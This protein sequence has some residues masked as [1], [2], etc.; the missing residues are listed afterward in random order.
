[1][2]ASSFEQRMAKQKAGEQRAR[3]REIYQVVAF[4][5]RMRR[6]RAREEAAA[7]REEARL[8]KEE[9]KKAKGDKAPKAAP[10]RF[11]QAV[12]S[13]A[14]RL[15]GSTGK[16]AASMLEL[17]GIGGIAS[18]VA[19]A[20]IGAVLSIADTIT[21][22]VKS[23]FM[24]LINLAYAAANYRKSA[25]GLGMGPGELQ[26]S[27]AAFGPYLDARAN[28]ENIKNIQGD[29]SKSW[30]LSTL[31]VNPNQSN[32]D[33]QEDMFEKTRK[34][35]QSSPS[36]MYLNVAKARGLDQV[37][38]PDEL[39][40]MRNMSNDE[41]EVHQKDLAIARQN[42]DLSDKVGRS[43][44]HLT[45]TLDLAKYRLEDSFI[46]ALVK[47]SPQ[48]E[49][50]TDAIVETITNLTQSGTLQKW[51][52]ALAEWIKKTGEIVA[53]DQFQDT[54]S[55]FLKA[56]KLMADVAYFLFDPIAATKSWLS[57]DTETRPADPNN[58]RLG[59][60][61]LFNFNGGGDASLQHGYSGGA[62]RSV[63]A[64]NSA[65]G[66]AFDSFGL[67]VRGVLFAESGGKAT[68]AYN[69][70]GGG[71][72]AR[73]VAQ[74]RGE[75]IRQFIAREGVDPAL[76][77]PEQQADFIRY[78]LATTKKAVAQHMA[79][80]KT[81]ADRARIFATEYEAPG[82]AG[83]AQDLKTAMRYVATTNV[84]VNVTTPPGSNYAASANALNAAGMASLTHFPG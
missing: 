29:V 32:L 21:K 4:E 52:M 57:G 72:G 12:K 60:D 84:K 14:G 68:G 79:Q 36:N 13:F 31:G 24:A 56:V 83:A 50:L 67:G 35:M 78:E 81:E 44:Q 15:A 61:G 63:Q 11:Q 8:K 38:S 54:V 34:L 58:P 59:P 71:F 7:Q 43:F 46:N 37:Y 70:A 9:E 80:A 2:A 42:L 41:L 1:M 20:A 18:L 22:V 45:V 53:S 64:F 39:R 27:M 65:A 73:G 49:V 23:A 5:E 82:T 6:Q 28:L 55:S 77:S 75:R 62:A 30:I 26:A 3:Q 10:D 17:A 51:I 16:G 48:L 25:M 66:S 19:G 76:A 33:V 47:V 40:R 74:W 69:P